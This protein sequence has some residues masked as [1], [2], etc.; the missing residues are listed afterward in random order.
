MARELDMPVVD[1]D[2]MAEIY[3]E[4]VQDWKDLCA[5]KEFWKFISGM[6]FPQMNHASTRKY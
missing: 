3:V 1:I 6:L 5:D 4:S 2:A